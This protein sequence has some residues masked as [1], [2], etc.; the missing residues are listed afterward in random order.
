MKSK[1]LKK[2][3]LSILSIL[4]LFCIYL[5][6]MYSNNK[7]KIIDSGKKVEEVIESNINF[8]NNA[9]IILKMNEIE[10][11]NRIIMVNPGVS[12]LANTDNNIINNYNLYLNVK[13]NEFLYSDQQNKSPEILIKVIT[14]EGIE[15]KEM[16]G[17]N[18]VE[19]DNVSGFDI[20][21]F[22]GSIKIID[23]YSITN[24]SKETPTIQE[25]SISFILTK[26]SISQEQNIGKN[27]KAELSL[28]KK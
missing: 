16:E 25:W 11:E 18:Y 3:L 12:L 5:G 4:I 7:T 15:L 26:L 2:I 20:T 27:F 21:E 10:T 17:L 9:E 23:N 13:D 1:L 24:D 6:I 19:F 28:E 14:P 22:K 8:Y